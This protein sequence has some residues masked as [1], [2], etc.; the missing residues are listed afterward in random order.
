MRDCMLD[1]ETMGN[2]PDAAI[3]AIG[4]VMF[5][6]GAGLG[7]RFYAEVDLG[8]SVLGGGVMDASTVTW[9]LKQSDAA[10]EPITSGRGLEIFTALSD[11]SAW[12][13]E[14][15]S[16]DALVWGNGSDFDNVILSSAYRRA[17]IERPWKYHANRCFRTLKALHPG[18]PYKHTGTA[19]NALDD[20]ISQAQH[21]CKLLEVASA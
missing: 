2:G 21:A 16:G 5:E 14:A 13:R 4:A 15:A 3:V 6:P 18:I 9:W 1:L 19:H 20:A 11:F 12:L 8:S 10:R 7:R 17:E